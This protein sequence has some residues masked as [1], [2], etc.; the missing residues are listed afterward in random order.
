M[1]TN[2]YWRKNLFSELYSIYSNEDLIGTLEEKLFSNSAMGSLNRKEYTFIKRGFLKQNID[3]VDNLTNKVI[4]TIR[5]SGL[6]TKAYL[7]INDESYLWKYDNFSGTKWT[8]LNSEG[9]KINYT[10]SFTSGLIFSETN[11]D[12]LILSGLYV[13]NYYFQVS[14]SFIILLFFISVLI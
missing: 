10:S 14:M 2:Y 6:M 12:L 4:G 9:I 5:F 3:I 8:V 1:S 13:S 7:T 11:D